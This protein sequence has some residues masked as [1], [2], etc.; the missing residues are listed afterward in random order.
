MLV[1]IALE[2]HKL[3]LVK[4]KRKRKKGK[5]E[6]FIIEHCDAVFVA[7][8]ELQTQRKK[9]K[10]MNG[11]G[12]SASTTEPS[13]KQ[14]KEERDGRSNV[15][16][17]ESEFELGIETEVQDQHQGDSDFAESA[18]PYG[19]L[20]DT[21]EKKGEGKRPATIKGLREQFDSELTA[22]KEKFSQCQS[23][24]RGENV[25]LKPSFGH[26]AGFDAF[27]TGYSF[28]SIAVSL[29]TAK[30]NG[31]SGACCMAEVAVERGQGILAGEL[32][33]MRNKLAN[34]RKAFPLHI[35]KSHFTSTSQQHKNAQLSIRGKYKTH[36]QEE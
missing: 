23:D 36:H 19:G 35:L 26:R 13:D 8:A 5:K 6:N 14:Q 33:E 34:R 18:V 20:V 12:E 4:A 28:A 16:P 15:E 2:E 10:L 27:M 25:K 3:E 29:C 11:E 32:E 7:Y 21:V 31:S 24:G 30:E 1:S 22:A 9:R 17:L